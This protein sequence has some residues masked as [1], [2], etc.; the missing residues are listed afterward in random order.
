MKLERSF[1]SNVFQTV[2]ETNSKKKI[3]IILTTSI[4]IARK[5]ETSTARQY[6]K[7]T[8]RNRRDDVY[9]VIRYNFIENFASDRPHRYK[10]TRMKFISRDHQRSKKKK[11][12]FETFTWYSTNLSHRFEIHRNLV[13]SRL[14]SSTKVL[15]RGQ[16]HTCDVRSSARDSCRERSLCGLG[17]T[18]FLGR[19][20]NLIRDVHT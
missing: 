19:P 9:L 14:R 2:F 3:K 18:F 20:S 8:R 1:N 11:K 13:G 12:N 17:N 16:C 7:S 4:R 6:F 15:K 10:A 5:P